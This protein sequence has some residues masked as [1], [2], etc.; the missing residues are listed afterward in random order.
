MANL[1]PNRPKR[2]MFFQLGPELTKT[3][4][5]WSIWTPFH[6]NGLSLANL[7]PNL[8][9]RPVVGSFGPQPTKFWCHLYS[10]YSQFIGQKIKNQLL[11]KVNI[12]FAYLEY[13][14]L[15]A[16]ITGHFV[17]VT[18]KKFL[19]NIPVFAFLISFEFIL[20]I[21]WHHAW[22]K[23]WIIKKIHKMDQVHQTENQI[24]MTL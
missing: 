20:Y 11:M 10:F 18:F 14:E 9:K 22:T 15:S 13:F 6:Q 1:N 2:L 19:W 4:R 8:P 24:K 21:C 5:N 7:D 12:I 23:V 17:Q 16:I 3:V